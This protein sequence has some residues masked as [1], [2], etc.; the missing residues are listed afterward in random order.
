MLSKWTPKYSVK[1]VG[2]ICMLLMKRSGMV[3]ASEL[4]VLLIVSRS[5]LLML[6]I[7]KLLLYSYLVR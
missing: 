6:S 1:V 4:F 5:V 7:R 3:L 2:V